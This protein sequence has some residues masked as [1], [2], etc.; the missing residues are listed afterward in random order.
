LLPAFGGTMHAVA[1]ALEHGVKVTGCT[2]HLVNDD[3]DRGPILLQ[4][5]VEVD[6]DD[7]IASLHARI[8]AQEH[9]L[10]PA[11]VRAFAEGRVRVEG[12]RARV[13]TSI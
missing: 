8:R 12:R 3:L 9:R 13:I 5:C 1:Q 6:E 11:A 2:I 10:L 4:Q 7:D